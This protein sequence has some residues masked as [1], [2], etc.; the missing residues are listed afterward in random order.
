[1]SAAAAAEEV[2]EAEEEETFVMEEAESMTGGATE[3]H[4]AHVK[5]SLRGHRPRNCM[6]SLDGKFSKHCGQ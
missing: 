1:M 4:S 5:H 3:P 2:E 6:A